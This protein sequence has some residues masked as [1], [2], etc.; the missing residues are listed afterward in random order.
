[1]NL[2]MKKIVPKTINPFPNLLIYFSYF[3]WKNCIVF[4]YYTFCSVWKYYLNLEKIE[5]SNQK[6]SNFWGMD[7]V[8][9]IR[10]RR[11]LN[12]N[13]ISLHR[14]EWSWT[15]TPTADTW[16]CIQGHPILHP[17][18]SATPKNGRGWGFEPGF[19]PCQAYTRLVALPVLIFT[20]IYSEHKENFW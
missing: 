9:S 15:G 1:M 20:I 11:H 13:Y 3:Y 12:S 8:D 5:A 18:Y 17:K 4:Y 2:K 19:H 7:P 6:V 10:K 14:L 16:L